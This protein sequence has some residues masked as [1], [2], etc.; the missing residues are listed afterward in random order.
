MADLN[1]DALWA[2]M[3]AYLDCDPRD[4]SVS[5]ERM[6]SA[7]RSAFA[8]YNEHPDDLAAWL[9]EAIREVQAQAWELGRRVSEE[10]MKHIYGGHGF[11]EDGESCDLCEN[12]DRNPYR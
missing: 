12:L 11:P 1:Q 4:A 6:S 10:T 7:L 2:A 8:W 5:R 9:P 3:D